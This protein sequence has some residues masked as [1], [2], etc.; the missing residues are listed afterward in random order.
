MP[1]RKLASPQIIIGCVGWPVSELSFYIA[2]GMDLRLAQNES[3]GRATS[4]VNL[5][6]PQNISI[7][8]SY[9]DGGML[10]ASESANIVIGEDCMISCGGPPAHRYGPCKVIPRIAATEGYINHRV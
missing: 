8:A 5:R 4:H 2:A 1:A 9:V 3:G 10:A 6:F 7:G